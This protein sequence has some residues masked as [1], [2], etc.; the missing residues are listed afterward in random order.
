M[1][2]ITTTGLTVWLASI[3]GFGH[4]AAL[5][6]SQVALVLKGFWLTQP[7]G[8]MGLAVPKASIGW[9]ILRIVGASR[10]TWQ[11]TSIWFLVISVFF[12][13]ALNAVLQFVQCDPPRALWTPGLASKCWNPNV[14]THFAIFDGSK[15]ENQFFFW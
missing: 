3:G 1:I 12:F 7:F 9:M 14:Q 4:L 11:K 10:T 2:F 15:H 5:S 8:I 6:P 13:N